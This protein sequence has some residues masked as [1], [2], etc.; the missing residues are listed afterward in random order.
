MRI[1]ID[2]KHDSKEELAH[3]ASMLKALASSASSGSTIVEN[4]IDRKLLKKGI[5]QDVFSSE[6]TSPEPA[7]SGGLFS[8]FADDSPSQPEQSAATPANDLFGSTIPSQATPEPQASP[9][10]SST[11][12]IFSMFN[13]TPAQEAASPTPA[14]SQTVAE[15][16]T[17]QEPEDDNTPP[18]TAREVFDDDSLV[19]Y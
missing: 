10:Q 18:S 11:G 12:D 9:S 6:P 7:S 14:N 4:R 16:L 13:D 5:R 15:L 3:L 1:E 19:P 8:L 2:T 17:Q